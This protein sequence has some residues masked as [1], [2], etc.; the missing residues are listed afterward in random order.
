MS[1]LPD[2]LADVERLMT[3]RMALV[4]ALEALE[5]A[6]SMSLD[7]DDRKKAAFDARAVLTKVRGAL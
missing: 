3:E 7:E 1:A 5:M 4:K 6:V 2:L